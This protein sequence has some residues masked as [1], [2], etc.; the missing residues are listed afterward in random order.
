MR[1]TIVAAG[2]ALTV[3]LPM[4]AASAKAEDFPATP[5]NAGAP[6][7]LPGERL[8]P[9]MTEAMMVVNAVTGPI[10]QPIL[11]PEGQTAA[12]AAPMMHR[13]HGHHHMMMHHKMKKKTM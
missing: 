6:T 11:V 1:K 10:V 8:V 4:L 12:A 13:H 7:N 5:L 2:L 3:A 9:G